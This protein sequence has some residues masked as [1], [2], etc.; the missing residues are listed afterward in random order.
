MSDM[1]G[2]MSG[3]AA[4]LAAMKAAA[5][6]ELPLHIVGITPC[7]ENMPDGGSY[8]PADVLT[9]S[10]GKTIEVISTDAEGRLILADALV[11]AQQFHP[12]AV[13]DL[14]TLTGACV[15]ALGENISAA[16]FCNNDHLRDQLLASGQRTHERTWSMPLWD[17]YKKV[18]KSQVA[19]LKNTGGRFSGV[20]SSAIFLKEFVDYP[21][22]HVDMASMDRIE[23]D[24]GYIPEGATGYGVRLLV[25]FLRNWRSE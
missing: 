16:L 9:A 13:V 14:A 24:D 1:K 10:N 12:A 7:T 25:D 23:K 22:A 3:A 5:M 21:W 6:L 18:L 11:Y 17:D 4:V 15:I 8:R 20:G 2:D 19:D